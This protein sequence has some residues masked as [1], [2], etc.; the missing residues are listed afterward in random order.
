MIVLVW[1]IG[2]RVMVNFLLKVNDN[3]TSDFVS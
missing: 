3:F 1:G 2:L